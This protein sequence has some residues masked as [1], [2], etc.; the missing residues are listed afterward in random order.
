M[1]SRH[2]TPLTRN[3]SNKPW[4]FK[5]IPVRPIVPE[6]I[7]PQ[8]PGPFGS[9]SAEEQYI[10]FI[11]QKLVQANL[12]MNGE[13]EHNY[14][15]NRNMRHSLTSVLLAKPP[16]VLNFYAQECTR[17]LVNYRAA[18]HEI[19]DHDEIRK[20]GL[21]V[22]F[23]TAWEMVKSVVQ[24]LIP[25]TTEKAKK[26]RAE[27]TMI[28]ALGDNIVTAEEEEGEKGGEVQEQDGGNV[29]V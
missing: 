10:E 17:D 1:S 26:D 2:S 27:A 12:F 14:D 6:P 24:I 21:D 25:G 23:Y 18:I 4:T 28:E 7:S 22:K 11:K 20:M 5:T 13:I 9:E 19:R 16:I 3:C 15:P 29:Q 8:D